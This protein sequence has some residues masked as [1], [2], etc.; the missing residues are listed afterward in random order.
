MQ[1]ISD[2]LQEMARDYLRLARNIVPPIQ[3]I[4]GYM[5][6][7]S[8]AYGKVGLASSQHRLEMCRLALKDDSNPWISVDCWEALQP[9]FIPTVRVLEHL[10]EEL[11]RKGIVLN[12]HEI[13]NLGINARPI[14]LCGADLVRAFQDYALWERTDVLMT[15]IINNLMFRL[16][17]LLV[18]LVWLWWIAGGRIAQ[19]SS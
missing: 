3:V 1:F 8:D 9:V 18:I 19:R 10:E 15:K 2:S 17:V 12:L 5:S 6:P 4:G 16:N 7:T 13:S 14:F 11:Q